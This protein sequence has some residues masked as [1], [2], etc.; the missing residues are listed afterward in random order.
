MHTVLYACKSINRGNKIRI[1][2][3]MRRSPS[4]LCTVVWGHAGPAPT[5]REKAR[6]SGGPVLYRPRR[7]G[8]HIII[9]TRNNI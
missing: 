8:C 7:G 9:I 2:L 6:L 1:L 4:L 5:C 3:G